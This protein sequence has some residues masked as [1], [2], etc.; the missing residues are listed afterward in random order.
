MARNYTVQTKILK[1]VA[2]VFD[3]VVSRDKL[4]RYFTS[5]SSGD[6]EEGKVIDW[7]WSHYEKTLQVVVTKVVA[8]RLIELTL[9][10]KTWEK[11]A[12]SSWSV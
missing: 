1:P 12:R 3:A 9:D 6:L 2:D 11:I 4:C 8:N 7:R 5:E 10:S